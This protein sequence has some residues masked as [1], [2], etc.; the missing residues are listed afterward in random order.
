MSGLVTVDP[1]HANIGSI[2]QDGGNPLGL[3]DGADLIPAGWADANVGFEVAGQ[4]L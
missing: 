2:T 4:G 3:T 1:T